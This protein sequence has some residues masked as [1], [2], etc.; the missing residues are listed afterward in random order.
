MKKFFEIPTVEVVHFNVCDILT[1][2]GD[3]THDNPTGNIED[4]YR[5]H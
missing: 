5:T 1:A 3:S 4:D 2:S